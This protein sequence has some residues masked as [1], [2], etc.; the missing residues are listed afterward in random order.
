L[1]SGQVTIVFQQGVSLSGQ[2]SIYLAT[3]SSLTMYVQQDASFSGQGIANGGGSSTN[4]AIVGTGTNY[5]LAYSGNSA[6]VGTIFAPYDNVKLSG[7]G[8]TSI[9]F[10]GSIV[11]NTADVS[12][13]YS[14]AYDELLASIGAQNIYLAAAWQEVNSN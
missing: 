1:V 13:S 5:D 4:L 10:A 7:G 11:A 6:Y 8:S 9:N 12:G 14:F 3:N 2:S